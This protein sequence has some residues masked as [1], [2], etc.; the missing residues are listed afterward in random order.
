MADEAAYA[1]IYTEHDLS[2]TIKSGQTFAFTDTGGGFAGAADGRPAEIRV[3]DGGYIIIARED[4]AGFWRRYFDLEASYDDLLQP[5]IGAA[6]TNAIPETGRSF[7]E[8]CAGTF[9]GLRLLRQPVWETICAF[10]ISANNNIGRI[11]SIYMNISR[12]YGDAFMW[13]GREYH[14]FPPAATLAA[15]GE[16]DLRG[17]GLGYRAAYIQKTAETIAIGGLPDLDAL[18]YEEAF[19]YLTGLRGVGEKVAECALLFSTR[20]RRAFPVDVW[21]ERI[22][23]EYFGMGGSRRVLRR[24]AEKLFGEAG[25][26]IQQ[27]MFHGIRSG[28]KLNEAGD[29]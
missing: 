22:L 14:T 9:K 21:V 13:N 19:R 23:R 17:L 5:F 28:L 6:E 16:G 18:E 8:L 27:Y 4:D 25:G 26:I 1:R 24:E 15:A 3:N 20:H 12:R 10:I 29:N 2:A 11:G 7:L